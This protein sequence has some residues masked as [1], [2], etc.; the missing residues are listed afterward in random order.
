MYDWSL[1]KFL[2][3]K[4]KLPIIPKGILTVEDCKLALKIKLMEFGFQ[5]MAVECLI[6]A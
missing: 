5:I 3:S 2:K 6:L 1:I 4:T